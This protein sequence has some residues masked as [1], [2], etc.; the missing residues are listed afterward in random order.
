MF[1]PCMLA[2]GIGTPPVDMPAI[3][4]PPMLQQEVPYPAVE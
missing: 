3:F 1:I 2:P 4:M